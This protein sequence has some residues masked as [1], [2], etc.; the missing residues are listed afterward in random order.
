MRAPR[1]QA[2][3]D[4]F[5]RYKVDY[6]KVHTVEYVAIEQERPRTSLDPEFSVPAFNEP[7]GMSI[8]VTFIGGGS[9][10]IDEPIP[11]IESFD[12]RDRSRW[13]AIQRPRHQ[14]K[15]RGAMGLDS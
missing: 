5:A 14:R 3:L 12:E 10:T 1:S 13:N 9:F 2:L 11:T 15:R 8:T 6:K 4:L 7:I